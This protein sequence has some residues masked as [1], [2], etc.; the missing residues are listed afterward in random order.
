MSTS[1][2][3]AN[4]GVVGLAVMGSNL[5]RNL[6]SREGNTVAV[7]N[8]SP[9]RTRKLVEEHPEAGFVASESI[10]DFVASLSRP[11]TAI[12][13]V[14]AGAGTDAVIGQLA[15]L[16]EDGDIIVDGGNANFRDTIRRE[17]ELRER[18]LNFVGTGISGGE[19]GALNGP[20]IMPGG[21]AEAYATL[22]PILES[23][24]ATAEGEPCVT[25]VGTD[26]AGH[27]VKMIHNGIEYA[28]MQLIAESYDLLRRVGGHD[29]DAIADVFAAWNEGDLE[30]YLIEITAEVLRQRDAETGRPLVDV[31]V[32]EAGSKGTGVW[33]VQNA[34]GLGIPVSGI[35][36]AVF[37]R[38]VSSKP[39]QRAAVRATIKER[40]QPA[41]VGEGFEDDVRAALYASKVV[42]YAQGFD[43]IIAGAREFGW[44]INLAN[45]A[46]I[47]RAG[48][49]I[50]AR[51]LNRIAD[52]YDAD[53]DLE[54]LLESPY[55][56]DAVRE[57]EA[58]WRR[59]V[60]VAAQSGV[61]AP[62]FSSALA[63]YDALASE[64]LPAALIQG[65][66]DFFGAHTYRRV[67]KDGVFHTLWSGDRS[68]VSA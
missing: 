27:F 64:R 40:P 60:A 35:G 14:Q 66:R 22:G 32:D 16:F 46:K 45:I 44:D 3:A 21:S 11:R 13:M 63:Y 23:I 55:F 19:E 34:V 6:A 41:E 54:T 50:R 8:R 58:A 51:F 67:D 18:G 61:P 20:S 24:A 31:I 30:S 17:R 10:E 38:A 2:E 47:W 9:E 56:A 15:D 28:D 59:I 62:G 42:A 26:G 1:S 29:T 37:A 25:H 53:P 39:S 12:I 4:I 57:G 33:T 43:A 52:A 36:E 5:A 49:I 48:C 68:E 7:Y 65:Q